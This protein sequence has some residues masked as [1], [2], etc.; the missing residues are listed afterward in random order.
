MN[1]KQLKDKLIAEAKKQGLDYAVVVQDE[2]TFGMISV[3]TISVADGSE[4]KFR[5]AI[6]SVEGFKMLKNILG[7]SDKMQGINLAMGVVGGYGTTGGLS[8]I[9][10]FGLLV[11]ELEVKAFQMPTLK[12]EQYVSRP[13]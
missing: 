12:E 10:P 1:E 5:N 7:T 11:E 6:V 8:V 2:S 3:T 4:K 13:Q 9:C